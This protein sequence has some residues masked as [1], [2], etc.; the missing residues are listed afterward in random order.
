MRTM[1]KGVMASAMTLLVAILAGCGQSEPPV[2]DMPMGTSESAEPVANHA[3]DATQQIAG[4]TGKQAPD[5][6][7]PIL[8]PG[9]GLM[10][11]EPGIEGNLAIRI[12]WSAT[13]VEGIPDEGLT[14]TIYNRVA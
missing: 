6:A 5:S 12:R 3:S 2:P 13:I 4:H 10:A 7:G 14:T 8:K 1:C 11:E 9:G